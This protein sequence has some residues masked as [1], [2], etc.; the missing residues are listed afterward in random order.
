MPPR[1]WVLGGAAGILLWWWLL[2]RVLRHSEDPPS[3]PPTLRVAAATASPPPPWW[4]LPPVS[5][6]GVI[7][8]EVRPLPHLEWFIPDVMAKTPPTWGV[9]LFTS[10]LNAQFVAA[11]AGVWN[12]TGRL[13]VW[14][15]LP[16][17]GAYAPTAQWANTLLR[18]PA[19]WEDAPYPRFLLVQADACICRTDVDFLQRVVG[20]EYVGSPL[21]PPEGA[22]ESSELFRGGNGGM[23]W[24]SVEGALRVLRSAWAAEHPVT[25]AG[26]NEDVWFMKGF[27]AV[28]RG[29][30]G[31][32]ELG[33][34]FSIEA[35]GVPGLP[36]PWGQHRAWKYLPPPQWEELVAHCP[37]AAR[38]RAAWEEVGQ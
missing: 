9:T 25:G 2:A 17:Y 34:A 31:S 30:L 22:D 7:I 10:P 16:K 28:S 1:R 23:S 15:M 11:H 14:E 20:V 6:Y 18:N 12:A 37:V 19:W 36:P 13:R 27:H 5:G 8:P 3:P 4:S 24:R 32:K 21:F 29:G 33:L 35:F 26:D 38:V